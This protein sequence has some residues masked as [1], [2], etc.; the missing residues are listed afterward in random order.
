MR[1]FVLIQTPT[2]SPAAGFSRSAGRSS[3]PRLTRRLDRWLDRH[4]AAIG[5]IAVVLAFIGAVDL[6]KHAVSLF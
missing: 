4:G 3:L 5:G 1:A 6:V 2:A